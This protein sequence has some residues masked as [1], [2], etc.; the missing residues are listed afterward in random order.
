MLERDAEI[1]G[2]MLPPQLDLARQYQILRSVTAVLQLPRPWLSSWLYPD[3][4]APAP[5]FRASYVSPPPREPRIGFNAVAP[6]APLAA[7][8][9]ALVI[10]SASP[11]TSGFVNPALET[12]RSEFYAAGSAVANCADLRLDG[13][14]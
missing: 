9:A 8:C 12:V 4:K 3:P 7:A 1:L 10:A 2:R 11:M 13:T 5:S 6:A 14:T